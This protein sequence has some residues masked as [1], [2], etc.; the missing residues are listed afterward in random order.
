ML[1]EYDGMISRDCT[2]AAH[3]LEASDGK[4]WF[5]TLGGIAVIDPMN[6]AVNEIAPP[7]AISRFQVD[8]EPV[9][10]RQNLDFAPGKKRFAFEFAG[11]SFLAPEKVRIRFRLEGFDEAWIDAGADRSVDYTN[12]PPDAYALRVIAANNDGVWNREGTT[13]RFRLRPYFYQRPVFYVVLVAFVALALRGLH[14]WRLRT[15]RQRNLELER[16]IAELERTQK[17]RQQ[18]FRQLESAAAEME[19]FVYTVSH[20]LKSPLISIKGFLGYL[21][22]DMAADQWDRA[23]GDA[24]HIEKTAD[25]MRRL[26]DELLELSRVGRV[27]SHPTEVSMSQLAAEA[28]ELVAGRIAERGVELVI[29]PD[30][31]VVLVDRQRLVQVFQNLIDNAVKFMGH[32]RAPRIEVGCRRRAGEERFF[33]RDNGRGI[34]PGD[35]EKAFE[36]FKRLHGGEGT[37][38][39][40]AI[41]ERIIEAHGGRTWAESEGKGHGATFWFTLGLV[42]K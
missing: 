20:D 6:L 28:A 21:R 36:I 33:V 12:L 1:D 39:G 17:E 2:G 30:M 11:L 42:K 31:P 15:V 38:I 18:L 35:L 14:R 27:V 24:D 13:L 32:E 19:R 29:E 5:P 10:S 16:I 34:D 41:V 26:V 7:V 4:L 9:F 37:G 8:R 40:L 25:K 3:F 22:K 23:A